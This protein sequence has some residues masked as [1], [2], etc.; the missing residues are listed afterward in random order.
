MRSVTKYLFAFAVFVLMAG[1][2][3]NAQEFAGGKRPRSLE[4]VAAK[5]HKE[6]VML[7]QYGLFDYITYQVNGDTVV[8]EGSTNSLGTKSGAEKVV[9]HIPGVTNV[10]NNI[11]ELPPSPFDDRI[12]QQLVQ[13]LGNA[14]VLSKYLFWNNPP[15]R[16]IVDH[17]HVTLEGYVDS[18]GDANTMY[19]LAN[20]VPG[21]FSV[22]NNLQVVSERVS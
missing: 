7:P 13:Q 18:S 6:I 4:G 16:L 19:V 9:R 1:T 11:R 14:G 20:G 5:V 2:A 10:V 17:G 3:A 22:T 15:V 12:R 21:V 8:L